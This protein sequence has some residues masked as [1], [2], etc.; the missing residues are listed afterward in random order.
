MKQCSFPHFRH[1]AALAAILAS[2]AACADTFWKGQGADSDFYNRSNWQNWWNGNYVFGGGQ[3]GILPQDGSYVTFTNAAAIA[4]GL[5]VENAGKGGVEWALADG[6]AADAG[7]TITNNL[8]VGT[9]KAGQL[10]VK[11]G[12]YLVR[13]DL[14]IAN[15][16]GSENNGTN[17]IFTLEDGTFEVDGFVNISP[18]S[19]MGEVVV[20]G[21]VLNSAKTRKDDDDAVFGVCKGYNGGT[22]SQGRLTVDGGI[23]NI[24]HRM[25]SNQESG[26][27][28]IDVK[29]GELNVAKSAVL[30][31]GWYNS[32]KVNLD[33][34]GGLFHVGSYFDFAP[35]TNGHTNEGTLTMSG[36]TLEVGGD[37][38]L[39]GDGSTVEATMTGG[40]IVCSSGKFVAGRDGACNFAMS[41]GNIKTLA[42]EIFIGGNDTNGKGDCVFTMTGGTVS[43][44]TSYTSVGRRNSGVLELQGGD[45]YS[46]NALSVGRYAGT[47]LIDMTGGHLATGNASGNN[48]IVGEGASGTFIM[49]GGTAEAN[50]EFWI[51]NDSGSSGLFVMTGG[52]FK[53]NRY[54]CVG[55]EK[56]TGKFIM[57][58]GTYTQN[59]EKFI[60][61]Q[62]SY[63]ECIVSNGVITV[64]NLW[65]AENSSAGGKLVMEGG[66]LNVTGE[67]QLS[68]NSGA[69]A[70]S[71]ELNGGT[72]SANY[73]V[74]SSGTGGEIIFNGGTLAARVSRDNFIP[75]I[76]N[77]ALKIAE[78][79][80]VIDTDGHSVTIADTFDN[81]DGLVGN[82]MIWKKGLG[83]LTISSDLD[84]ARTFKFTINNGVGPIALTGTG[85]TLDTANGA[86]LT[87]AL[88]PHQVAIGTTY[89]LLS[90]LGELTTDDMVLPA[91]DDMYSYG[92]ALT[93]GTLSVTVTGYAAGAPVTARY[94]NGEWVLYDGNGNVTTKP[95]SES[96]AYVFTGAEPSGAL[97]SISAT[98]RVTLESG[99]FSI[100]TPVTAGMVTIPENATVTLSGS[101]AASF[102]A[103]ELVNNGTL[104]F[105]E[106][107]TFDAPL[108]GGNINIEE[109]AV[110]SLAQSQSPT[111]V[112]TGTGELLLEN[113]DLHVTNTSYFQSFQ[114][115]IT[116]GEGARLYDD[117]EWHCESKQGAN[118][119]WYGLGE[120]TTIKMAGGSIPRFSAGG[121]NNEYIG[122]VV[123]ADG[124]D[125]EWINTYSRGGWQGLNIE[126]KGS[127]SGTGTLRAT[128]SG[129]HYRFESD[130]SEFGG[131]VEMS[132]SAFGFRY[133]I[134]GGTWIANSGS[135]LYDNLSVNN[136]TL[137][138]KG[139]H[140]TDP[141]ISIGAT[142]VLKVADDAAVQGI[143]FAAG[144]QLELLDDGALSDTTQSYVALVS[145]TPISGPLPTLVQPETVNRRGSWRLFVESV[146]IPAEEEGG[147]STYEYHLTARFAPSGFIIIVR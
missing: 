101:D 106:V 124:T 6:A 67:A 46:K 27:S 121:S 14:I 97:E 20:K 10:T 40:N 53:A 23:V 77:L 135:V 12:D 109:G 37:L 147:D 139:N 44:M 104:T 91:E 41:G 59:S 143:S 94:E 133:G 29:S 64:P 119:A 9:G 87:V 128:C 11:N 138:I 33:V 115:T 55:H 145:A 43:N 19:G 51:G 110:L 103:T 18:S 34:S 74:N 82:G 28:W 13:G 47:G 69:G 16:N 3:L 52:V 113:V 140:S 86:K 98:R 125:N 116:V 72:L 123:I 137:V 68:R 80:A 107:I 38:L 17:S 83:T 42:N 25:Y 15:G 50:W 85:N 90:G 32:S 71:I 79:G 102:T 31:R 95:E 130:L 142:G 99:T 118:H 114:G 93:D 131:T 84:L 126:L 60:V 61:G 63:G 48:L 57:N 30:G 5:W 39:A 56:G 21:G 76:S 127:F 136:A 144:A 89:T 88:D 62:K 117:V 24:A 70:A 129:R 92:W 66:T 58:G 35:R 54:T 78:G 141:T 8:T 122:N 105:A 22:A 75:N 120:H 2:S 45:F 132:G 7:L 36:G 134:N 1:A 65:L 26:T 49:G 112:F 4:Q 73:F 108:A 81:A 146:E 100:S 111:A 96:T